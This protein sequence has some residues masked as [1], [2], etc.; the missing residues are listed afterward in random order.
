ML[1]PS[2][3]CGPAAASPWVMWQKMTLARGV[4]IGVAGVKN[5]WAP[6]VN[7]IGPV[8]GPCLCVFVCVCVCVC[9]C[10]QY[11]TNVPKGDWK[12]GVMWSWCVCV[13]MKDDDRGRLRCTHRGLPGKNQCSDWLTDCHLSLSLLRCNYW[14]GIAALLRVINPNHTARSDSDGDQTRAVDPAVVQLQFCPNL[15]EI[16]S[17]S[18]SAFCSVVKTT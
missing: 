3:V 16:T 7:G 12:K 8:G 6:V 17:G 11:V 2:L 10:L 13:M 1:L 4:C 15:V 14:G 18:T 5:Q 9:V